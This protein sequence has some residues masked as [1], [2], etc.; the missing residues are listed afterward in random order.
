MP[1]DFV[2]VC[3]YDR[4]LFR[5]LHIYYSTI[6]GWAASYRGKTRF[7]AELEDCV[8]STISAGWIKKADALE[9]TDICLRGADRLDEMEWGKCTR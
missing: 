2:E 6:R 9:I 7:F 1:A 4:G 5:H 3:S 8:Q